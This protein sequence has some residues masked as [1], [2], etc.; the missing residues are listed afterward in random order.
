[1]ILITGYFGIKARSLLQTL[2][3]FLNFRTLT[4]TPHDRGQTN[5][6]YSGQ[7]G[8]PGDIGQGKLI[9]NDPLANFDLLT[10]LVQQRFHFRIMVLALLSTGI[11]L[12][13]G[14]PQLVLQMLRQTQG[15]QALGQLLVVKIISFI[16]LKLVLLSNW[17]LQKAP[18][19]E[20]IE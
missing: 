17:I 12:S 5:K 6:I 3:V 16:S 9:A 8:H 20:H 10:K 15:K 13:G 2:V 1:M 11:Q 14:M 7:Y 18:C 19:M 4:A